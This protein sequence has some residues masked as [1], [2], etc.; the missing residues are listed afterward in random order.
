MQIKDYR[1]SHAAK[2]YGNRYEKSFSAD[3]RAGFYW[4]NYELPFLNKLFAELAGNNSG[5]VLDFA[6][7]TGRIT[8]VLNNY[9]SDITAIDVSEEMLRIARKTLPE[10]KYYQADLSR[11]KIFTRKFKI[12]TAFRFL[13]NAQPELREKCLA[14][15]YEH[16]Y[17]DGILIIN[18]HLRYASAKGCFIAFLQN[19][20]LWKE[21]NYLEDEKL[22][23]IMKKHGFTISK[24]FSCCLIPGSQRF[25][26]VSRQ[27]HLKI[28]KLLGRFFSV[29]N[30]GEQSIYIC[31]KIK[32]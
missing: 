7:G 22:A 32:K 9:F 19:F 10:V 23:T 5:P 4:Q 26:P 6:C 8:K 3:R 16:L 25:P 13:L 31:R 30:F 1:K 17:D 21:R 14:Q 24:V 15:L 27:L 2:G 18:N 11:E 28:E 20:G 29:K 12:I